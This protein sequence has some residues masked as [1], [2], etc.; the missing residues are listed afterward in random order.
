MTP[1]DILKPL[2]VSFS[3]GGQAMVDLQAVTQ[4]RDLLVSAKDIAIRGWHLFSPWGDYVSSSN[5]FNNTNETITLHNEAVVTRETLPIAPDLR[6]E[7]TRV[8]GKVQNVEWL[9]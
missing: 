6:I 1:L 4:S 2:Y 9:K 3:G 5:P 7:V 8:D